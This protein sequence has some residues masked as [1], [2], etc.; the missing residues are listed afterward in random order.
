MSGD[1]LIVV[2]KPGGMTSHDVVARLRRLARTRRVGHGGTLDPMATGVLVI[3]VGRATRLLT[4]VIGADKSY[5]AT[6]RLGQATVTDDAEGDVIATTPAGRITD[7]AV[8][9]A[10]AALTGEIDQ[11][12]SAVSA[13]KINGQRAYKRVR[14]GESVELPARRVTVSRLDV[15]A[16]R[17]D[18]PDVVDVDIE[19]SCSTGTYI[20]AIARDAGLALGVGGHLTALR[21]TSVGGFGLAES[22]TLEELE[23]RAPD[24]IGLPLAVA[25][26]RFFPRRDAGADEAKVLSHGG[27]LDAVGLVGPYAVFDPAGGVIAIVSERD[28]RARAEIVL[29]P[30]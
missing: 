26:E 7:D 1:G 28:G 22:V 11:V 18:E 25:A 21:R 12:P 9:S 30:A 8:R 24:V 5:A 14:E 6:I 10:L 29:A 4:Y 2:D 17:R 19:V 16:V 20:R 27:P 3:G 15:L 13:I 23:R